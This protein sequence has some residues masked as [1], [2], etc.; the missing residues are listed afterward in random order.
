MRFLPT[1]LPTKRPLLGRF[2]PFVGSLN[3]RISRAAPHKVDRMGQP[4]TLSMVGRIGARSL[5]LLTV[6]VSRT[7]PWT[8]G[9][10]GRIPWKVVRTSIPPRQDRRPCSRTAGLDV[11]RNPSPGHQGEPAACWEGAPTGS[12][13]AVL[14]ARH[15]G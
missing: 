5:A 4:R 12:P 8:P 7:L 9:R 11:A 1:N 10:A 2:V 6:R 14:G 15:A 3:G 13:A